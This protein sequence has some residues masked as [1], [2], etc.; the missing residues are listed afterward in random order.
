MVVG[1]GGVVEGGGV[2]GTKC[3]MAR[4][5]KEWLR[6][7]VILEM[8]EAKVSFAKVNGGIAAVE[9]FI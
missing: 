1:G 7:V 6:R 3:G 5:A 4:W 8:Q 9:L 2:M